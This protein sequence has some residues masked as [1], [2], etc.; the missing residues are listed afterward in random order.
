MEEKKSADGRQEVIEP[1]EKEDKQLDVTPTTEGKYTTSSPSVIYHCYVTNYISAIV[2]QSKIDIG[3]HNFLSFHPINVLTS[4]NF[5]ISKPFLLNVLSF[6][7][8][9]TSHFNHN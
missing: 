7:F 4:P 5:C 9:M 1:E 8:I 6:H 2:T 3:C